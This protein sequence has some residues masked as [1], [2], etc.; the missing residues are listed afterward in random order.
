M[1]ISQFLHCTNLNHM[2]AIAEKF[3]FAKWLPY[4]NLTVSVLYT[5]HM[6]QLFEEAN[7]CTN[8]LEWEHDMNR[9]SMSFSTHCW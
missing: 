1:P 6:W 4:G 5:V 8:T 3:L 9:K 7:S 2:A